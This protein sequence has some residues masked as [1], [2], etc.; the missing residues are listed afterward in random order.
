MAAPASDFAALPSVPATGWRAWRDRLLLQEDLNFLLTNRVPRIALSR[1]LGWFSTLRQPLVRDVSI[2]VWRLCSD[3]DLSDAKKTRFDSLQD[4][5]T[6]ELRDGARPLDPDTAALLSPSDGILGAHG[7]IARGQM[8]QAKGMPY[9]LVD[10]LGCRQ[11]AEAAEGCAYLT[12]RLTSAMYHRFHAPHDATVLDLHHLDGDTWN[13]NPIALRRV[14]ALFCRNERAAIRLRLQPAGGPMT[15]V[16]VAAVG[17][18]GLR[19]HGV[20]EL[21]RAGQRGPAHHRMDRP[22]RRGEEL[23]W[24]QHGSTIIVVAPPGYALCPG[25]MAGHRLRMGQRLLLPGGPAGPL[26]DPARAH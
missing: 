25:L 12:I 2:A 10:L 17:V 15:L 6:R 26:G 9:S 18:S 13:V 11:A 24:F 20:P 19:V 23:G 21:M 3:L 5:F 7:H 8:L 14:Q 16:P 4:C 22:V 1:A